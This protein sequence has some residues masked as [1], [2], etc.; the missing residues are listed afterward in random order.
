[1][2]NTADQELTLACG[3]S[4]HQPLI[5]ITIQTFG[6]RMVLALYV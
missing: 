1:M 5:N 2:N 4:P 3:L 6:E